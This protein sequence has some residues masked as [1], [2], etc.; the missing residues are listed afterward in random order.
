MRRWY[1]ALTFLLLL[2]GSGW[3]QSLQVDSVGYLPATGYYLIYGRDSLG[4]WQL[5]E[6]LT[7]EEY[8]RAWAL[9]QS[10]EVFYE[11]GRVP[12]SVALPQRP[13]LG[14]TANGYLS[15]NL[16]QTITEEDNPLLP[17]G[18]RKRRHFLLLP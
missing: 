9:R 1:V 16:S 3:A 17:V 8:F 7:S 10:G 14:L 15:L 4:G 12:H 18:L 5:R 2:S 13:K 6:L 11:K